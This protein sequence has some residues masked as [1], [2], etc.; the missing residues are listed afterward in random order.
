MKFVFFKDYSFEKIILDDPNNP[1]IGK[2]T[3]GDYD[4]EFNM[5]RN[6]FRN[7]IYKR[8]ESTK[9]ELNDLNKKIKKRCQA[10]D[11]V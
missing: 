2:K 3:S 7:E 9:I 6:S 1:E 10:I 11:A 4:I 8:K 5:K